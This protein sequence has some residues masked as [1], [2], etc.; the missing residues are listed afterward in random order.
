MKRIYILVIAVLAMTHS[1]AQ[2]INDGLRYSLE[3]NIGTARFTAL[4]GAMGALGGDVSA[5]RVNPAGGAVFVTGNVTLTASLSDIEN[6]ASYFN[7]TENSFSNKLNLS[8]AGGVFVFNNPNEESS[9]KKFT[10]GFNYDTSKNFDNELYFSGRGNNSIG[11][12]FLEQAQ[13]ISMDLFELQGNE[14]ISDLYAYLG[15]THGTAAQNAFLGYQGFLFNPLDPEN[16]DN[17]QYISNIGSGSFNQEFMY[18]S[19]GYN[20]KFTLNFATQITD[21]FYVGANLNTHSIDF[22]R[23]TLL[24]ESNSNPGSFVNAV[25]FENNLYVRGAGISAQFGGIAKIAENLRLGLAFDTPTWYDISE[26][27]SQYLESRRLED[28]KNVTAVIN[29]NVRNIYENYT[30][31][32]PG[33]LTGSIAYIFGQHGLVSFD[34]SY[35]DHSNIKFSPEGPSSYFNALNKSIENTLTGVSTYKIGAEY[36]IDLF[37]LRGGYSYEESPYK[38]N[39]T[40]GD[41]QGFSLGAGYNLGSY[42]F[43]LAYSRTQQDRFEQMYSIGLTDTAQVKSIYSNFMLSVGFNF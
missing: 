24:V 37:S 21:D 5:M 28:G 8:Q 11:D 22:R 9:F 23:S 2:N 14:T 43:D 19:K 12:F 38:D 40:L 34:Y 18:L 3:D 7:N 6:K 41:L 42:F 26:E 1:Q 29:P 35:K 17:N 4:S 27:T 30:L 36:R 25:G 39:E 15:E 16:P 20:S 10:I 32:T 13:G 33:K 31:R